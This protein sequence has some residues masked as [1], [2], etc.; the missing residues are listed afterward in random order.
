MNY[1]KSINKIFEYEQ[2]SLNKKEKEKLLLPYFSFLNHHHKDKCIAYRNIINKLFIENKLDIIQSLDSLPYIPVQLFKDYEL[3]SIPKYEVFKTMLSSGTSSSKL[4]KIFL[5]KETS[6]L[7]TKVLSNI[8]SSFLGKK[9]LPMLIIDC[10]KTIKDR[11]FFSVRRAATLGF[12]IFA[13]DIY[14]ALDDDMNLNMNNIKRFEHI[15]K[16]NNSLIFGFTNII[17]S[18]FINSILKNKITIELDKA[19]LIHGGGW[20]KLADQKITSKN[21]KEFLFKTTK[22]SNVVNYYGMV[23]QTGSVYMECEKGFLHCSNFA[24]ILIRNENNF[25]VNKFNQKGLIQVLSILPYSYPGHSLL[26]EDIGQIYGE[27]NCACGRKGKYFKV[28][29][30]IPKSEIRGCSD[31]Y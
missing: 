12:S 1:T 29:G 14:F 20:K 18:N 17:W 11:N 26:T 24:D 30:R 16:N 25:S 23:E 8:V 3:M 19:I 31:A 2:Y 28:F 9:R 22:I 10:P 21:F 4:S 6:S 15:S 5:N 27:D 13:K 7:Q